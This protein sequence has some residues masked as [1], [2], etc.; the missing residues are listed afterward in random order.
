MKVAWTTPE[1][2]GALEQQLKSARELMEGH[3]LKTEGERELAVRHVR[4]LETLVDG[5]PTTPL[6]ARH[7]E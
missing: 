6:P 7:Y 3:R 1:M 2:H 4:L 5:V